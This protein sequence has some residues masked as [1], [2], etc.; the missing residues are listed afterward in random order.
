MPMYMSIDF[1][2]IKC[3]HV[4]LVCAEQEPQALSLFVRI[5][6]SNEK[7][8]CNRGLVCLSLNGAWPGVCH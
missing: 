1:V 8:D 6:R 4:A 7:L 2:L 5:R 3:T